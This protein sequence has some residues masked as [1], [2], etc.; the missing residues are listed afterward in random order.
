MFVGECGVQI[1]MLYEHKING[2]KSSNIDIMQYMTIEESDYTD[3]LV[4][5]T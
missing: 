5:M 1:D 3:M 2:R 4:Y